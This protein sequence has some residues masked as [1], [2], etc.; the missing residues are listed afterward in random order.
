MLREH[1]ISQWGPKSF[2]L[3]QF[4]CLFQF[5]VPLF[6]NFQFSDIELVNWGNV[7]NG[8]VQPDVV[9][10]RNKLLHHCPGIVKG[11]RYAGPD[12]FSLDS[13]MKTLQ[14]AVGL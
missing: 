1:R 9:V 6:E 14:L 10:V 13:G 3:P 11:K 12:A 8:T 5:P 7:A 4:P 2:C